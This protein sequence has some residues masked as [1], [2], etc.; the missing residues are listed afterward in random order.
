MLQLCL[1]SH[2]YELIVPLLPLLVV[3][4]VLLVVLGIVIMEMEMALLRGV[5]AAY[6]CLVPRPY[7]F[8]LS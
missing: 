2:H 1:L 8:N 6:A 5:K 3:F 4:L 7:I